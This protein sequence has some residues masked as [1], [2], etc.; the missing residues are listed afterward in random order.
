MP[1]HTWMTH[2]CNF[3]GL[4]RHL[5]AADLAYDWARQILDMH[6]HH[7]EPFLVWAA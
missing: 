4:R 7:A 3:V 5:R 2:L 6:M 1:S